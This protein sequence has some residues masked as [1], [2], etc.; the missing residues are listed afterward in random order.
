MWTEGVQGL[1]SPWVSSVA[2]K[3]CTVDVFLLIQ[4]RWFQSFVYVMFLYFLSLLF[5]IIVNYFFKKHTLSYYV[6][7]TFA[8]WMI[9][10]VTDFGDS[11]RALQRSQLGVP[12]GAPRAP[13]NFQNYHHKLVLSKPCRLRFARFPPLATEALAPCSSALFCAEVTWYPS[14]DQR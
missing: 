9:H 1:W 3:S 5:I 13:I 6:L 10:P 12:L 14:K 11:T 7:L 8:A 2:L 4:G